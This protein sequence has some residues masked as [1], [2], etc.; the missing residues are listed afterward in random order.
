M[1]NR[2]NTSLAEVWGHHLT[3]DAG[4]CSNGLITDPDYLEGWV[5]DLVEKI[6]MVAYG[7]PQIVHFGKNEPHLSGWTVIQLIETSN[8]V[9]H[10]C[11]NTDQAYI[12]VFSCKPFPVDMAC[13]HIL[14]WFCPSSMRTNFL[15][16]NA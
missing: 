14:D 12:D 8:I 1:I 6:G 3:I 11:D 16:R 7:E 13:Q 15:T 4:G 10:F 2:M 9:A 5:K